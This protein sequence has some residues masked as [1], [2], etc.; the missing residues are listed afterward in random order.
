M[1]SFAAPGGQTRT[2]GSVLLVAVR[3]WPVMPAPSSRVLTAVM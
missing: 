2:S 1:A 3:F